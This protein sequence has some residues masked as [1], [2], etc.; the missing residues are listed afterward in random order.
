MLIGKNIIVTRAKAQASKFASLLESYGANV[1]LCPT[2]EIVP[3]KDF[4]P[5]DQAI[6]NLDS[7]DWILFTS[8]NGVEKFFERFRKI[9]TDPLGSVP[10]FPKK[11]RTAAIGPLTAEKMRDYKI[12]VDFISKNYVAESVLEKMPVRLNEKVLIPQAVKARD[13]LSEGLS[14]QGAIVE[15]V[16]VY[17]TVVDASKVSELKKWLKE[18]KVDCV[19]FTSSSTVHNFFSLLG[20][21]EKKELI[22]SSVRAASIGPI[23]TQ[24]LKEEGWQ[25]HIVAS[26]PTTAHLA[27]ALGQFYAR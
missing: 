27:Q 19:T 25:A 22:G 21:A 9:G 4:A 17:D 23:T 8:V 3:P 5:L 12:S 18:A 10:I 2:I 6:K 11:L 14:K 13:I 15:S 16:K 24:T 7:Y 20:D 1:L 26:K